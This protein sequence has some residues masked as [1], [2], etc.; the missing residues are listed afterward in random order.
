LDG[1][2]HALDPNHSGADSAKKSLPDA[3]FSGSY[4][5]NF[6]L[7]PQGT[8]KAFIIVTHQIQDFLQ[9]IKDVNWCKNCLKFG[10][11]SLPNFSYRDIEIY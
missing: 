1:I 2:L 9:Q 3:E 10:I 4:R 5:V 7:D 6:G 8:G 11:A